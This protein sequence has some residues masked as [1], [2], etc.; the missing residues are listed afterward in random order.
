MT[1]RIALSFDCDFVIHSNQTC[2]Q[3]QQLHLLRQLCCG[4][5]VFNSLIT[6][7]RFPPSLISSLHNSQNFAHLCSHIPVNLLKMPF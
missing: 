3:K 6:N 4:S 5:L 2:D 1:K 7:R